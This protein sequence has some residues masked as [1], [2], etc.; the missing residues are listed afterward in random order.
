M[1]GLNSTR[2]IRGY[3]SLCK[4]W[5]PVVSHV[6]DGVFIEV[7][8]DDEHPLACGICVKAEAGPELV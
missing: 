1:H 7:V 2:K 6:M 5:C 4:C 3:C 8:P